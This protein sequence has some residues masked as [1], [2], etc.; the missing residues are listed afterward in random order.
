MRNL[1]S[2]LLILATACTLPAQ[3]HPSSW[4]NLNAL[5]PGQRIQ[6]VDATSQK[7]SGAFVS[8]SG[9]AIVLT[10]SNG[11]QTL[12]KQDVRSVQLAKG[13]HHL[14]NALIGA[15]IGAGAGAGITAAAWESHGF[16]G[17]KGAG[18]AVGA[19]IGGI[20][21]AIIGAVLPS[22]NTLYRASSH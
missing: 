10:Q 16:L 13:G 19:V 17:S 7:H 18:A 12:Q 4:D 5:H 2:A 15:G 21:G 22:H 11:D 14:R 1:L 20:S 3:T 9:T 6:I 8:V